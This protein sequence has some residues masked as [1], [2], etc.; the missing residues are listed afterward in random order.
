[1]SRT[2]VRLAAVSTAAL[3][4]AVNATSVQASPPREKVVAP[5]VVSTATVTKVLTII[6]ENHSYAQMK[7]GMPYLFSLSKKYGYASNWTAITHPSL[8]NYLAMTGGSTFGVTDDSAPSA[9]A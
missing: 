3:A 5:S 8:P 2:L 4:I 1:M 7:A 6:E 9:N